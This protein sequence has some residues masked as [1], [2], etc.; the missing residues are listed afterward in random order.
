MHWVRVAHLS[1][2]LFFIL[3]PF[4]QFVCLDRPFVIAPLAFSS[5]YFLFQT[6]LSLQPTHCNQHDPS[7]KL[8]FLKDD[9]PRTNLATFDS[10]LDELM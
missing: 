10:K 9:Q 1:S 7:P 2:F 4:A 6:K 5:G 3:L 8:F